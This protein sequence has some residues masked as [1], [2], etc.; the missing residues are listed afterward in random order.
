MR[1]GGLQRPVEGL[2]LQRAL[3]LLALR[4]RDVNRP[5]PY[6]HPD[7]V[8]RKAL[9]GARRLGHV[10]LVDLFAAAVSEATVTSQADRCCLYVVQLA[11][12]TIV[13]GASATCGE[14]VG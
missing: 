2:D 4:L 9:D 13:P 7:A 12:D 11:A 10:E 14:A 3:R 5:Q 1:S 8:L 6:L